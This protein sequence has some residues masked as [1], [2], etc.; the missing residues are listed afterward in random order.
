MRKRL[1]KRNTY[2]SFFWRPLN[3]SSR[4]NLFIKSWFFEDQKRYHEKRVQNP[5]LYSTPKRW[6]INTHES[7]H[8]MTLCIYVSTYITLHFITFTCT[9]TDTIIQTYKHT[10]IQTY[11][12]TY[13]TL[14]Y[15][16]LHYITYIYIHLYVYMVQACN[17][18]PPTPVMV[19]VPRPPC[20]NG[21]VSCLYVC[22]HAC[23]HA[24]M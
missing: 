3:Q 24:S 9:Y 14:H 1:E 11:E 19:M 15:I 22:M 2:F 10:N 7:Q 8:H 6:I 17:P 13:I 16:T 4:Y 21:G 18:H 5:L 23:V 12:H 20:G